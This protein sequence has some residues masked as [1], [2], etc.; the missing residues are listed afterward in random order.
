MDGEFVRKKRWN[1]QFSMV[2]ARLNKLETKVKL[3]SDFVNDLKNLIIA[4][5]TNMDLRLHASLEDT[6]VSSSDK[7]RPLLPTPT[8]DGHWFFL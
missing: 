4:M 3:I 6:S 1:T 8:K 7:N 2:D 5:D